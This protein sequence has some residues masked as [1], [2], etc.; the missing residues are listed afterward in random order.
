MKRVFLAHSSKDKDVVRAVALELDDA[1]IPCWLDESEIKIGDSLIGKI[2]EAIDVTS[3]VVVFLS[4]ASVQSPWV[5]FELEQ[6]MT[7]EIEGRTVVVLPVLLEK[8]PVPLVLRAKLYADLSD[9]QDEDR[10]K[11]EFG[12]LVASIRPDAGPPLGVARVRLLLVERLKARYQDLLSTARNFHEQRDTQGA[13]S[14][15]LKAVELVPEAPGA[16]VNLGL[17]SAS[18]GRDAEAERYWLEALKRDPNS[19]S[20][21]FNLG[22]FYLNCKD[23]K[24]AKEYLRK[25]IAEEGEYCDRARKFLRSLRAGKGTWVT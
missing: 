4:R 1:G 18:E 2:A 7:K 24:R 16:Y 6:A 13:R 25:T 11:V 19:E 9:L 14:V 3:H 17:I 8:C 23:W 15:L 10:W 12:K 21:L 22:M 5:R 20:A